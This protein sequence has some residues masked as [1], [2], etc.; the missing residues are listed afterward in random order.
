MFQPSLQRDT[1]LTA[2]R[3]LDRTL[4]HKYANLSHFMTP[5]YFGRFD[6]DIRREEELA[7]HLDMIRPSLF[8]FSQITRHTTDGSVNVR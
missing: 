3:I 1:K 7:T 6:D 2:D 5:K 4:Y 8:T